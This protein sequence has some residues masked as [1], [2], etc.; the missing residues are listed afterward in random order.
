MG[1]SKYSPKALSDAV[2]NL[3]SLLIAP[4][5]TR[6]VPRILA[7]CG[8]RFVIV[9]KLPK[10]DIDGVCFWLGDS[11]VIG[12]STR[13]DK[14]D[15]FWFVLRHEIEHVLQGDGKK[16]E[17]IDAD[18]EGKNASTDPSLPKEERVANAAAGNFCAPAEKLDMFMKR[19]HPFYYEKDVIA[20]A[21]IHQR[22][23]GLVVGQMQKRMDRYDYLARWLVKVRHFVLPGARVDGW[24]QVAPVSL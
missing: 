18:L 21:R 1:A 14:I 12:M 8:V 3:E 20:F 11:P 4:E 22:H 13:R 17:I 5:E 19:K 16:E 10:A 7:E 9:E 24:G 15:N 23:P 2:R 6:H